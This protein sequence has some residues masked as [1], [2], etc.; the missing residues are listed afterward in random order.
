MTSRLVVPAVVGCLAVQEALYKAIFTQN[1]NLSTHDLYGY[2]TGP[3]FLPWN[4]MGNIFSW[5]AC[6]LTAWR[7]LWRPQ[8]RWGPTTR[9]RN[10]PF[11]LYSPRLHVNVAHRVM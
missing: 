5:Y 11:S 2:F 4:R 6:L 8:L 1:Y 3:A 9:C 10:I 7:D